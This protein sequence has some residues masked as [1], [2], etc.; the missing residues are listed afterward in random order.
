[1]VQSGEEIDR[2][3]K[4][5]MTLLIL[6]AIAIAMGVVGMIAG[7]AFDDL[8]KRPPAAAG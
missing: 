1:L 7:E 2:V 3:E 5:K 4:N 6:I 8:V